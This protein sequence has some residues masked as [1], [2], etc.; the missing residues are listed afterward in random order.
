MKTAEDAEYAVDL[1]SEHNKA[2]GGVWL[3]I[4]PVG[5]IPSGA[6]FQAEG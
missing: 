1:R 6:V 5:V 3:L 4:Q 2:D